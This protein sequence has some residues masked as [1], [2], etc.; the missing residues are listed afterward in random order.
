[1]KNDIFKNSLIGLAL[2][3][4]VGLSSAVLMIPSPALAKPSH[5]VP[6]AQTKADAKKTRD[7]TQVK[8]KH[9]LDKKLVSGRTP[10]KT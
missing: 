4:T 3:S 1:M 7:E 6:S 10:F 2:A 5:A 8:R 9:N